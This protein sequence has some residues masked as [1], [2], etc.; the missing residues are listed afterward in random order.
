MRRTGNVLVA[1]DVRMTTGGF[2]FT[3][4]LGGGIIGDGRSGVIGGGNI[5]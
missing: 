2:G 1:A 3:M 4:V 5:G